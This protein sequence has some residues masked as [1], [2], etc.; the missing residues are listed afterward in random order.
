[1]T[2]KYPDDYGIEIA[3]K[4]N[5]IKEFRQKDINAYQ[6]LRKRGLLDIAC[7]HMIRCKAKQI[8]RTDEELMQIAKLYKSRSEFIDKNK[9]A[10]SI[11]QQ[12]GILEVVC[13]HMIR[14]IF[15]IP[16]RIC[17]FIFDIILQQDGLYNTRKIIAPLEIDI[18]YEK[19]NFAIE[20]DGR[21]WH[22]LSK[23]EIRRK[24]KIKRLQEKNIYLLVIKEKVIS[25][26]TKN[27]IIAYTKDI[28]QQILDN[29]DTI[30]SICNI[31]INAR[32]IENIEIDNAI[33]Y[34]V[35]N[36]YDINSAID[37]CVDI[38]EFSKKYRKYYKQ[39]MRLDKLQLLDKLRTVCSWKGIT[40]EDLI[41]QA[42]NKHKKY[43]EFALDTQLYRECAKRKLLNII[44]QY[45]PRIQDIQYREGKIRWHTMSDDVYKK[46]VMDNFDSYNSLY[47]NRSC[48]N[49]AKQ[50]NLRDFFRNYYVNL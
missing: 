6:L 31:E 39:L 32:F 25:K 22:E 19:S 2:Q 4:Y 34:D 48:Y 33:I 47:K 11:A 3:K 23:V 37:Q 44:Q 38:R 46:Y 5:T 15:S 20:Y 13:K 8:F 35:I 30:N 17:K 43:S 16:Q 10:Y 18:F 29:I 7:S 40:N 36:W 14:H 1:M 41:K 50:R 28:K 12:R 45:M 9:N 42:L 49:I 27:D 21:Y 24:E 26:N